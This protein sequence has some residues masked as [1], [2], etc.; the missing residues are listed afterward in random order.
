MQSTIVRLAVSIARSSVSAAATSRAVEKLMPLYGGTL[1]TDDRLLLNLFQRIELT[2]G[3][4][5]SVAFRKWNPSLDQSPPESTRA[6]TL[7]ALQVGYVRRSWLRACASTRTTFP[8]EHANITYDPE[9]LL[10]FLS[11]AIVEEE[12]KASDWLGFLE[13]GVLGLAVAALASSS[14]S[15][16]RLA[17]STLAD[18]LV[19]IEVRSIPVPLTH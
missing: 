16:C 10:P 9:F 4:P 13:T 11:H 6:G 19:K 5:L 14:P 3:H 18:S 17:Q 12:L 15:L 8:V 1:S 2:V 7:A